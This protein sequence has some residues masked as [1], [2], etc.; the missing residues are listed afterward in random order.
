M[1]VAP[2]V[3]EWHQ[4]DRSGR[5]LDE[6]RLGPPRCARPP[7][8]AREPLVAQEW[9]GLPAL[10]NDRGPRGAQGLE[11]G[12]G[13]DPTRLHRDP[14]RPARGFGAGGGGPTL[15]TLSTSPCTGTVSTLQAYFVETSTCPRAPM[16]V[17]ASW[18][19][20]R[21]RIWFANSRGA[22]ATKR[23]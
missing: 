9:R 15:A 11:L 8:A 5:V 18:S 13:F 20:S 2:P 3:C 1:Q 23:S 17:A 7:P 21:W 22:S 12:Y 10:S 19:R 6:K 16:S 14:R 4:A